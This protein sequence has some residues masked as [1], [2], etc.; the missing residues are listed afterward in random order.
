[1][2]L[3]F[4][5]WRWSPTF[6]QLLSSTLG[7]QLPSVLCR[8]KWGC[9]GPGSGM[10]NAEVGNGGISWPWLTHGIESS[11][12]QSFASYLVAVQWLILSMQNL[13]QN[14]WKLKAKFHLKCLLTNL[15]MLGLA[16]W[17]GTAIPLVVF[18]TLARISVSFF[19]TVP[20]IGNGDGLLCWNFGSGCKFIWD[21]I[22]C[23]HSLV[24]QETCGCF[25]LRSYAFL[26]LMKTWKS[27]FFLSFPCC[28]LRS[29]TSSSNKKREISW[30]AC[31][32]QKR[33]IPRTSSFSGNSTCRSWQR[34]LMDFVLGIVSGFLQLTLGEAAFGS[35]LC[36]IAV[37]S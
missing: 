22:S 2:P 8:N 35:C 19:I 12:P 18:S 9:H 23:S 4:S 37:P 5:V 26:Q 29:L 17:Y 11:D 27:S 33:R 14:K 13:M 31:V 15:L 7:P 32:H 20:L 36:H 24:F 6:L 25:G 34:K 28:P 16:L 3:S 10:S 30:R 21:S 1:M